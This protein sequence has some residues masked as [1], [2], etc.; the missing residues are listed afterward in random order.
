MTYVKICGITNIHDA[1]VAVEAG[2]DLLGFVFYPPSPRYV[3]VEQARA[4]IIKVKAQSSFVK[5]VGVFVDVSPSDVRAVMQGAG[6]DLAQLHGSE[7][8]EWVQE[9]SPHVYKSLQPTDTRDADILLERY[10]AVSGTNTPAFILDGKPQLLPGGNGARADW[11][12]ASEV[13]RAFPILL[14]GGL[15]VENVSEAI[16]VVRPWGVDVSSGVERVRGIKD[17]AKVSEFISRAKAVSRI[18][19]VH[20]RE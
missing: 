9:L 20:A 10:R 19:D 11:T 18:G 8:N 1:L 12:I 6:L 14:A 16:S 3:T 5:T 13:A 17:H 4:I 15:T 2:A 7:P